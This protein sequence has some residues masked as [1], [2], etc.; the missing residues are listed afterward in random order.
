MCLFF[1]F[2]FVSSIIN[3]SSSDWNDCFTFLSLRCISLVQIFPVLSASAPPVRTMASRSGA[4]RAVLPA[5]LLISTALWLSISI[6][7]LGISTSVSMHF[8]WRLDRLPMRTGPCSTRLRYLRSR[9]SQTLIWP[10]MRSSALCARHA[11]MPP[12]VRAARPV[13]SVTRESMS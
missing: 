1:F 6:S 8:L 9:S 2:F 4:S 13:S 10:H 12:R 11:A 3:V 7:F 5:S